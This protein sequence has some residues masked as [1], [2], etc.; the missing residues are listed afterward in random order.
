LKW[1]NKFIVWI[2]PIFP[3]SFIWLFSRRYVA[4][5]SLSDAISKTKDLNAIGCCATIDVL[6]EDIATLDEAAISRNESLRVLDAIH[7]HKLNANLSVKLTSLG[8]NIDKEVCYQNVL[9][10][11]KKARDLKNFVRID[12][13]DSTC[14][15]A[16]LE[17]YQRIREKYKNVGTVIQAYLKRSHDDV[18]SL[19]NNKTAHLR[20]CKGIYN[21]SPEI[22]IKNKE[23]IRESFIELITMI[24]QSKSYVGIATHDKVIIDRS[25]EKL[26]FQNVNTADYEFQMLLGVSEKLRGELI[27]LG[28]RL[29]VYIPYGEHWYGYSTRRLKEN[30]QIAGHIIKNL[31]LRR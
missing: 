13:E 2:L 7:E 29:R 30:P 10:I 18:V 24:L 1:F 11:V 17:I 14:T 26:K 5:K 23:K 6:G 31:F 3:K 12:M 8:L 19:I 15:D 16:T 21:E 28:H 25:I 27:I 9:Q 4:G 22:A 20:L